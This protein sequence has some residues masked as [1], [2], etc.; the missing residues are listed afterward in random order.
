MSKPTFTDTC[1]GVFLQLGTIPAEIYL[2]GIMDRLPEG[3]VVKTAIRDTLR[4]GK[5]GLDKA[6]EVMKAE[7]ERQKTAPKIEL[8]DTNTVA[9]VTAGRND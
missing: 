5:E 9:E 4:E 6:T 8:P 7:M 1:A 2:K 3:N